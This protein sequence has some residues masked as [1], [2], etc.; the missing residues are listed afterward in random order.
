MIWTVAGGLYEA[1]VSDT[2]TQREI[3]TL[4]AAGRSLTAA[5]AGRDAE[6]ERLR[7]RARHG[8]VALLALD[9]IYG[10]ASEAA[11][12]LGLRGKTRT[13]AEQ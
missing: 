5:L 1:V 9:E 4:R 12:R 6:I 11:D 10:R 3:H 7:R 2:A 13:G 8:D